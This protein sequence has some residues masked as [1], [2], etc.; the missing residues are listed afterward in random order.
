MKHHLYDKEQY[1]VSLISKDIREATKQI[2]GVYAGYVTGV[3]ARF[4]SDD[5][6]I[7]DVA[8]ESFVRIF[9]K[10]KTFRYLGR[11][12]L[13]AWLNRITVNCALNYLRYN[14]KLRFTDYPDILPDIAEAPPDTESLTAEEIT[15]LIRKLPDG[16][17][18]V[19]NLYAIEGKS[20]K[21]I[22]RLLGIKENSSASQYL[23][24]KTM[25]AMKIKEYLKQ[26]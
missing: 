20:H 7:K 12:S 8:Q 21:E 18:R 6:D 3:C 22:G 15:S 19:F 23:R 2:Y 24:A 26:K 17:R 16:Y 25:L 10:L 4:L 13:I 5:D 9:S 1:I 14:S 11:G